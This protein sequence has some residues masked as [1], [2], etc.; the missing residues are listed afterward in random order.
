MD[1]KTIIAFVLIGLIL[2]LMQ[3][4]FYQKKILKV[5]PKN[6]LQHV[7]QDTTKSKAKDSLIPGA[8]TEL[9]K[10]APVAAVATEQVAEQKRNLKT[11]PFED[12]LNTGETTNYHDIEI[13]TDVYVAKISPKGGVISQWTLKKYNYDG[14]QKVELIQDNGYGNL[15][16]AFI[17]KGDTLNT[18]NALFIPN[19]QK[20]D[21]SGDNL[22]DTLKLTLDLGNDRKIIKRMVFHR[23]EYII[24]L[25]VTLVNLRNFFDDGI[26][27]LNWESG[28]KYT[29]L[30]YLG[31]ISKE[32]VNYSKAY[33]YQGDEKE[34]LKLP[35]KPGVRKHRSDFSGSVDW[36]AIRTKYFTMIILPETDKEI[37]PTLYGETSTI[38]NDKDLKDRVLKKYAIRLKNQLPPTNANIVTQGYR[39]YVGPMDYFRLK[40]Y[41]PTLAKLMDFGMSLIRPFSKLVLR[42]FIFMHHFIPNYGL[43]LILFAILIKVIVWPLTR[44]SY[45]SMHRMQSLQPKLNELKEKYSKDPQR[46]NKETMKLYKEE[47]VNPVSGCLP[48]LLQMPLLFAIFII[49]RNTIELRDASFIW[50]IKD[51]SAPDTIAV[52]PFSIPFYGNLVNVL[53]ILMGITMFLQQ[54]MTMRD[55]KQ[56]AMVYMM[57]AFFTLLFNSFPSG[58]NLYYTLFNLFSI[59]QQKYVP[60]VQS[61]PEQKVITKPV[62]IN[63]VNQKK[64]KRNRK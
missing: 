1:K 17:Y 23:D 8:E 5:T 58:L 24:D 53:P 59:I 3:T 39:V 51:L 43:V 19:K 34:E 28:L 46:L 21:F 57:P 48:Q 54:K 37:E 20:I 14:D 38:Y 62:V 12:I 50:W 7:T 13:E 42:I 45:V 6:Q 56:K 52:L 61:T 32:D 33:V 22:T 40:K 30:D 2:V 41:H 60:E 4:D 36:T 55:P 26:Y 29:E 64:K 15:G 44:K 18:Y 63:P 47:G 35:E 16:I 10:S 25:D 27:F 9:Q 11:N 31:H 49:F